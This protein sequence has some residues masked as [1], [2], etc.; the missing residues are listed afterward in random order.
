MSCV[1]NGSSLGRARNG[2][3]PPHVRTWGNQQAFES[4]PNPTDPITTTQIDM[5]AWRAQAARTEAESR[6]RAEEDVA[7]ERSSLKEARSALETERGEL[8]R[9]VARAEV[10]GQASANE[11]CVLFCGT[12]LASPSLLKIRPTQQVTLEPSVSTH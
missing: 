11:V 4:A 2:A 6:T 9:R 7:R 3:P 5:E 10:A 12:K 8:L 1:H